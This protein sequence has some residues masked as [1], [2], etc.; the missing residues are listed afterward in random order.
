MHYLGIDVS[1][2]SL[3]LSDPSGRFAGKFK[4]T[5]ADARRLID[6]TACKLD[7]GVHFVLEPT[8][9]YHHALVEELSKC[10][11]A[12][13]VINL[14]RTKAYAAS[15]GVRAK[16]DKVDAR[17]LA[18]L[19]ETQQ[20]RSSHHPDPFQERIKSLRRHRESIDQ[21]LNSVRNRLEA[22][23]H[24]PWTDGEATRSL[25]HDQAS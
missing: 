24:S 9:T 11:V 21:D 12:Y 6:R 5:H 19:G 2:A 18:S 20:L 22:A 15:L 14:A 23:S 16:T 1:K 13:T 4:N 25:R 3:D 10:E 8:S 17:L 7:S